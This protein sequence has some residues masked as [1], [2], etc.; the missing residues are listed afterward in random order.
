MVLMGERNWT[1]QALH[2]ACAV[3]RQQGTII[4]L[5]WMMP[6]QYTGWIGTPLGN[7]SFSSQEYADFMAYRET[8]EDYGV[9]LCLCQMQYHTLHEAIAEAAEHLDASLVFATLPHM[10][11]NLWR[12]YLLRRLRRQLEI[13]G[14]QLYTLEPHQSTKNWVPAVS[15]PSSK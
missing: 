14:S 10:T 8:A 15:L 7:S 3:A 4:H 2:L 12:K 5:V 1:L 6:V 13:Q 9:E 11:F